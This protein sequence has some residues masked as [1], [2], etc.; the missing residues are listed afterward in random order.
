[1]STQPINGTDR[2]RSRQPDHT[3][4]GRQRAE[5][6]RPRNPQGAGDER[7]KPARDSHTG[8][9]GRN[10]QDVEPGTRRKTEPST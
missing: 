8:E 7:L 9:T 4:S 2:A 10:P 3:Q 6:D 1:M 5:Q